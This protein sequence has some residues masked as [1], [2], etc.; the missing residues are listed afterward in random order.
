MKRNGYI[1]LKFL[2]DQFVDTI[3]GLEGTIL[4]DGNILGTSERI[5]NALMSVLYR[6]RV[7][8]KRDIALGQMKPGTVNYLQT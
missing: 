4:K 5:F 8:H 2:L 7:H 3:R 6:D 1:S